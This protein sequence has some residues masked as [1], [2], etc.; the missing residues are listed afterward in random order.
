MK[1]KLQIEKHR[2][3]R[4]YADFVLLFGI[5]GKGFFTIFEAP[6][7]MEAVAKRLVFLTFWI[8]YP[9]VLIMTPH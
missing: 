9:N 2:T 1:N 3:L 6:K 4:R 8:V 7:A 5:L